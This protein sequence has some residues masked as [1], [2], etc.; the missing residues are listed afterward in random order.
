MMG[1]AVVD[2]FNTKVV[3][4]EAEEDGA[5]FVVSKTGSGG[6]LVVSMLG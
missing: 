1:I 2:I 3:D 6:A 4:D 5:P